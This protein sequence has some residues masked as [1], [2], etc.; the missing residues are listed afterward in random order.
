MA[1]T[2]CCDSARGIGSNPIAKELTTNPQ[3][4]KPKV[5][6][7]KPVEY[8]RQLLDAEAARTAAIR[9]EKIRKTQKWVANSNLIPEIANALDAGEMSLTDAFNAA[10]LSKEEQVALIYVGE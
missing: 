6:C 7:M 8:A 10:K 4:F 3:T 9:A 2:L 5:K 1:C